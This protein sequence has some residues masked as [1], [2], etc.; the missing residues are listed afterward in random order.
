MCAV[1][2]KPEKL[3][4]VYFPHSIR[5]SF[6]SE[7][8]PTKEK[9]VEQEENKGFHAAE[10]AVSLMTRLMTEEL[11]RVKK[12]LFKGLDYLKPK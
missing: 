3:A 10:K 5:Q 8:F 4:I 7:T 11:E 12:F 1:G 6:G 2:C 9:K